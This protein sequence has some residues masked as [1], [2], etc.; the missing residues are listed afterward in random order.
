MPGPRSLMTI[1]SEVVCGCAAPLLG[2]LQQVEFDRAAAAVTNGIA[3]Q[4][5]DRGG[6]A[7]LVLRIE[8]QQRTHLSR[9]LTGRDDVTILRELEPSRERF[10]TMSS[11]DN[12]Q[13]IIA[14]AF[15][16]PI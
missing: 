8:S 10:M 16:V 2:R 4:L 11:N 12:D 6:D 1:C 7:D 14:A 5:G 9:A 3:S 13:G 15:A